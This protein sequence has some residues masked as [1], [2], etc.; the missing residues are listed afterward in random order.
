MYSADFRWRAITLHYAYSIAC[1]QVGRIFGV[2]GRTVRR[3]YKYFKSSGHVIPDKSRKC[4]GPTL[5]PL[6]RL[7]R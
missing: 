7:T 6:L 3:W 4:N 1:E 5:C 2:S